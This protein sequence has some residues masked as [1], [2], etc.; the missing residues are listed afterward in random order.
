LKGLRF[1]VA[2]RRQRPPPAAA[3]RARLA[4]CRT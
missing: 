2:D 1:P 3:G 4:A